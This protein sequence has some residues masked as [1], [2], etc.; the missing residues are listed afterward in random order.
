MNAGALHT[1]ITDGLYPEMA[2]KRSKNE[3]GLRLLCKCGKKGGLQH[4]VGMRSLQLGLKL[5]LDTVAGDQKADELGTT[6]SLGNR[7]HH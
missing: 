1:I 5:Q 7:N 2:A 6:L 4:M 3:D